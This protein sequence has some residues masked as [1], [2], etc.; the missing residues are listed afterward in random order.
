MPR[1]TH[2]AFSDESHQN[3]GRF[4]GISLISLKKEHLGDLYVGMA[5]YS[6]NYYKRYRYYFQTYSPSRQMTLFNVGAENSVK[7]SNADKQRCQLILEF[8]KLCKSKKMGIS[9][10]SYEGLKTPDPKNPVN[11]WWYEPQH[12][13]DKAPLR[14]K[15]QK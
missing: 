6:R 9:L 11:F 15:H 3:I 1:A 4:R 2:V 13:L 10:D 8:N 7:L 12:E 14:Q 5:I